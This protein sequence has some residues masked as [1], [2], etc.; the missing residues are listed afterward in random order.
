L[1][2]V[3][4]TRLISSW[5]SA[6][7]N[8]R[9]SGAHRFGGTLQEIPEKFDRK[10]D[11]NPKQLG[12]LVIGFGVRDH[13]FI[14]VIRKTRARV[15]GKLANDLAFAAIDDH[16]G[17]ILGKVCAA[18][19]SEQMFLTLG[20]GDLNEG[21]GRQAT[22]V[23]QHHT[24]HLNLIVRCEML[25]QPRW[26]MIHRRHPCADFGFYP[27]FN[28]RDEMTQDII[29]DLHLVCAQTLRVT[30][31]KICDLPKGADSLRRRAAS[32]GF[33]KFDDNGNWL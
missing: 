17:D 1:A 5:S 30:E 14:A 7:A 22:R 11:P 13:A 18:R 12:K 21:I 8:R 2:N 31:E 4:N 10:I 19:N 6:G 29:E 28:A 26:S 3:F 16:I 33:F 27:C 25:D 20:P 24:S 15:T 23:G 32:D 9:Q